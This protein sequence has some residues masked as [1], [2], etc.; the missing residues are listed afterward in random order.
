MSTYPDSGYGPAVHGK[1]SDISGDKE[2]NAD[3]LGGNAG[4]KFDVGKA[5]R[6][7]TDWNACCFLDTAV[8]LHPRCLERGSE[9]T[10]TLLLTLRRSIDRMLLLLRCTGKTPR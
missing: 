4:S 9:Y 8:N 7:N 10:R 2:P 5:M 1:P 3:A 6:P